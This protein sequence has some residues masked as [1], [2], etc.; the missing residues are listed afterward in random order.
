MVVVEK[1][2]I[3]V[4]P[5]DISRQSSSIIFAS[6]HVSATNTPAMTVHATGNFTTDATFGGKPT[7]VSYVDPSR[8]QQALQKLREVLAKSGVQIDLTMEAT[9]HGPTS[10]P[11]PVCFI[12]IGSEPKEWTNP[13]LGEMAADGIMAAAIANHGKGS[14]VVGFGGTH[15]SAK[16]TRLNLEGRYQIGHVVPRH[17][18]EPGVSESLVRDTLQKTLSPKVTALVDWKGISGEDR[19]RLVANLE[20]WGYLV[21]RC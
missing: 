14:A 12:E 9:H 1:S 5:S 19:R 3:Y 11:V 18:L 10:F 15:Y 6:K 8:I 20:D 7:E 17:A 16:F 4:E 21:E 13:I 2:P